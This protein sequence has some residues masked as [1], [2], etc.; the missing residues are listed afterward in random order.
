MSE[1]RLEATLWDLDGVIADTGTYHCRAWQYVFRKRGVSFTEE[2]FRRHFGQR[3]DTIIRSAIGDSIS[4]EE[5]DAI[6]REKEANYR[7]RVA[8]NIKPLPGAEELIRSLRQHG[9]K[10]AIASSA[11]LENIRLII[12]GLG[13][14]D[15]FQAIVYGREVTEGKPSPQVFLLAASKLGTEPRDCLVI[16]D[17]VAGVAAAKRAG[18]KCLAVTNSHSRNSLKEAD[19]IVDTLEAVSVDTLSGLFRQPLTK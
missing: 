8:R 4:Q 19:F 10:L 9:I 18:M 1:G 7:R 17:A 11:P 5:L 13:I 14:E 6:A 15:C 3:N 2:D 12:R 16:E